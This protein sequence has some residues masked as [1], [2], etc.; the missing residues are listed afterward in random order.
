MSPRQ[1]ISTPT[2]PDGAMGA[3]SALVPL[4]RPA[5]SPDHDQEA[6]VRKA[7]L[8]VGSSGKFSSDRA[9]AEYAADIWGRKLARCRKV[10]WRV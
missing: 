8:N 7:I 1:A 2:G 10:V 3:S 5:P 9:I 4:D 6:W